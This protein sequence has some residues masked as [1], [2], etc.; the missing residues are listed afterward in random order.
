[1]SVPYNG[2]TCPDL[3]SASEKVVFPSK[4]YVQGKTIIHR[5]RAILTDYS[6]TNAQRVELIFMAVSAGNAGENWQGA[7]YVAKT[8]GHSVDFVKKN[9]QVLRENGYIQSIQRGQG[10]PARTRFPWH[11]QFRSEV[12]SRPLLN[13]E[14][15]PPAVHQDALLGVHPGTLPSFKAEKNMEKQEEK[16]QLQLQL[17]AG[18]FSAESA[19]TTGPNPEPPAVDQPAPIASSAVPAEP[20]PTKAEQP[21]TAT[22]DL[23][24]VQRVLSGTTRAGLYGSMQPYEPRLVFNCARRFVPDVTPAEVEEFIGAAFHVKGRRPWQTPGVFYCRDGVLATGVSRHNPIGIADW[25]PGHRDCVRAM[26]AVPDPQPFFSTEHLRE[27]PEDCPN[28]HGAGV[29]TSENRR[30]LADGS[31]ETQIVPCWCWCPAGDK[32]L[33]TKGEA[34]LESFRIPPVRQERAAADVCV[35]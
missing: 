4:D 34:Y 7:E 33:E 17:G 30:R 20:P 35:A 16:L 9:R 3:S 22:L 15:G 13:P 21:D 23:T 1:M 29:V 25:M 19:E 8:L 32:L 18:A 2:N 24:P 14:P 12:D 11:P 27:H 28:C 6:L 26:E 31:V 10:K 5:I